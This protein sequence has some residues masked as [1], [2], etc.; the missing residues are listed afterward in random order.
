M[1]AK[2]KESKTDKVLNHLQTYGFITSL[3]AI[4]LYGA[5]RLSAIIYNLRRKYDIDS[6]PIRC[7]DRFGNTARYVKY[8]L[9]RDS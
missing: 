1:K 3:E 2:A 7:T 4:N 8:T 6:N 5:T 9:R